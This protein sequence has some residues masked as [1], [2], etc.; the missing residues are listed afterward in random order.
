MH[1]VS[2]SSVLLRWIFRIFWLGLLFFSCVLVVIT[3]AYF[4][5]RTDINFLLAKQDFV[6]D[7]VWMTV[8]YLHISSSIFCLLT[9]PFQFISF[10]RDRLRINWHRY[11]GKVYIFS[12]LF[13]AAPTGAYMAVF[14]N[15]GFGTQL[16]FIILSV[17]WFVST[18][19]AWQA[20]L[21]KNIQQHKRW[22]L[23][24]FAL[25][26]SAVTLR[27]WMPILSAY[28][29]L[30]PDFVVVITAWI[31]WLPNILFAELILVFFPKYL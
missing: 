18:Y 8:F 30:D 7:K 10:L 23:R 20:I 11:L 3:L 17:L 9:G 6:K 1:I 25:T 27:L 21:E 29:G 15:G 14:A 19:F 28:W 22:M 13:L 16:G 12:I 24:S 31:N 26:F 4:S 2:G 5:F